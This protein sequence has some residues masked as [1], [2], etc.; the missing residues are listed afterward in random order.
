MRRAYRAADWAALVRQ[1]ARPH[2]RDRL[3]GVSFT[4]AAQLL[5]ISRNRVHQLVKA[6]KLSVAD[7]FDGRTRIGHLVTL[8]SIDHR[9]RTVKPRRTQWRKEAPVGPHA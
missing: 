3:V 9:R 8:A 2:D 6:G 4:L 1:C 7:V 5:R